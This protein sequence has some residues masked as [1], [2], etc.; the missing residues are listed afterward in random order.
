MST[1]EMKIAGITGQMES[2][3][4]RSHRSEPTIL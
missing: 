1:H 3:M 4:G 2:N